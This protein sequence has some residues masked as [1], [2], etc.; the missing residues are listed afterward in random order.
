MTETKRCRKCEKDFT[1]TQNQIKKHDWLCPECRRAY[2]RKWS[3]GRRSR[4]LPSGGIMSLEWWKQYW[5]KYGQRPSVK[6]KKALQMRS[7]RKDSTLRS[8]HMARWLVARALAAG[9]LKKQP[10]VV[11]GKKHSQA[12]HSDYG[13]PLLVTW[14]CRKCHQREH[15]KAEGGAES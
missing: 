10:C 14:L 4:G 2:M 5:K 11:C 7:Y 6:A 15:A 9:R 13:K 3:K 12:H 1:P 8:K